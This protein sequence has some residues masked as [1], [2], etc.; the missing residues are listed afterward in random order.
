MGSRAAV[1][2]PFKSDR[3]EPSHPFMDSPGGY[4]EFMSYKRRVLA[5]V[6]HSA[7]NGPGR[8]PLRRVRHPSTVR[9][10]GKARRVRRAAK[11]CH[12]MKCK[13]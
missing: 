5:L 7:H 8:P 4:P 2:Q 1:S 6:D 12:V 13:N 3:S 10:H 9:R 11:H